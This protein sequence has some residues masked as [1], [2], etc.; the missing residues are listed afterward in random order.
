M[1]LEFHAHVKNCSLIRSCCKSF[2][3]VRATL[4]GVSCGMA[5]CVVHDTREE[6]EAVPGSPGGAG[7][8]PWRARIGVGRPRPAHW[9]GWLSFGSWWA[10]PAVIPVAWQGREDKGRPSMARGEDERPLLVHRESR[11]PSPT[12]R[13]RGGSSPAGRVGWAGGRSGR[14]GVDR[15]SFRT[16]GEGGRTGGGHPSRV[17]RTR[18]RSWRAGRAVGPPRR[19]GIGAGRPRPMTWGGLAVVPV[20][21][22]WTGGHS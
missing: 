15:R 19:A 22:G 10:E 5:S 9:V 14:G 16:R 21:V 12:R 3:Q 13:D 6:Q 17:G 11:R 1:S 8:R 18:G 4:R 20:A 7:C 2:R